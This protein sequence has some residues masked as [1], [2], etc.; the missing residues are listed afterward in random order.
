MHPMGTMKNEE[1][2]MKNEELA[3]QHSRG[4]PI[5]NS[6]FSILHSPFFLH[7]FAALAPGMTFA[8]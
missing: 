2:G 3:S 6:S 7:W 1:R 5:L 4:R 8:P